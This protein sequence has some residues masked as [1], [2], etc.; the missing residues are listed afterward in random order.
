MSSIR[1]LPAEALSEQLARL[2]RPWIADEGALDAG[3]ERGPLDRPPRER[4]LAFDATTTVRWDESG[5]QVLTAG[6]PEP[7]VVM[8]ESEVLVRENTRPAGLAQLRRF[9]YLAGGVLLGSRYTAEEA[10]HA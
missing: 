2:D 10:P 3:F 9:D 1:H 6:P 8:L 4:G 5:L 7:G